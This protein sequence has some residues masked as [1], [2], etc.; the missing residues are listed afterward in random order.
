[1]GGIIA[2]TPKTLS[3]DRECG[4]TGKLQDIGICRMPS[5]GRQISVSGF[6]R[7]A[8]YCEKLVVVDDR[9][10]IQILDL[11]SQ[12]KTSDEQ[13]KCLRSIAEVRACYFA[14]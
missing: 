2:K 5:F 4:N 6:H 14:Y 11:L 7:K 1:M 13:E 12:A 8:Q 9:Q 3:F 10:A